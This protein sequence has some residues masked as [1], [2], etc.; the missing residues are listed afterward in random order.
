MKVGK[1]LVFTFVALII[2]IVAYVSYSPKGADEH[3]HYHAGFRVYIDG[4]LQDYS[5]YKYMNF[6]PCSEHDEKKS[7]AE[8]QIEKAHLHDG[9]GDVVHVHRSG[10]T[11]GDLF[12]NIGIDLPIYLPI[13]KDPIEPDSSVIIT[14]GKTVD[15]PEKVSVE[16]IKE[17]EAKSELCGSGE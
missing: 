7:A 17:I 2:T 14:L 13:L 15:N 5:D 16:H 6:V 8:E 11:W 10:S 3:L 1:A 4:Q 12:K 9:V